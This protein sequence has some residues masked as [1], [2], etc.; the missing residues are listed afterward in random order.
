MKH[1]M[2]HLVWD[3]LWNEGELVIHDNFFSID[4]T[5]QKDMLSDWITDL[6]KL[7]D[8]IKIDQPITELALPRLKRIFFAH[9]EQ[10]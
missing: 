1:S 3:P 2:I 5:A 7:N 10:T 9:R 8:Q 6:T 4:G